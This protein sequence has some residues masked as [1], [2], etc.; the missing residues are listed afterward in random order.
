MVLVSALILLIRVYQA[1]A[2][3]RKN[4]ALDSEK[5]DF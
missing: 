1:R 2:E 4:P 3:K 5:R